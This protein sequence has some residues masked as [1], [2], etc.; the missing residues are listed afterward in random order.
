MALEV[1]VSLTPSKIATFKDCGLAFRFSAIDKLPEPPSVPATRGTLVHAALE[2][3]FGLPAEE[4]TVEAA[5]TCLDQAVLAMADDPEYVGLG[6]SD[7]QA[8]TFRA[9][10]AVLVRRYFELEDPSTIRPI[11]L[12]LKL[13]VEVDLPSGSNVTLRGIID[14]LELDADGSLVVTD[15]KSGKPPGPR[16]EQQR[17]GG[18]HFYAFLCEQLFGE[19][20]SRVQLLYLG[21][22]HPQ[23]IAINRTEQSTRGLQRRVAAIWT[24]IERACEQES[25]KPQVTALCDW[26]AFKAHCPAF[27]GDPDAARLELVG[28]A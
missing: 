27:G 14:R 22:G 8:A 28:A 17:L 23:S 16:Q 9:E 5:I 24:A 13:E 25:F 18:V 1:P 26:C 6:L 7:E 21:G 2:R 4:R 20:P 3:L 19:R 11:G 10:A 15:Y 12:E